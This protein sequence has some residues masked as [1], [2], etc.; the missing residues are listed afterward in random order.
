MRWDR[1]YWCMCP[2]G[3]SWSENRPQSEEKYLSTALTHK[4]WYK[5]AQKCVW[6]L[7]LYEC[8]YVRWKISEVCAHLCGTWGHL[9][10]EHALR[11]ISS[12]VFLRESW[13]E[14]DT[15]T[16]RMNL[17][18]AK[19]GEK[20]KGCEREREREIYYLKSDRK[21]DLKSRQLNLAKCWEY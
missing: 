15:N 12:T 14:R 18:R 17:I 8:H 3:I 11:L 19:N 4:A 1:I 20:V 2:P 13:S 6:K 10:S 9:P 21:W 7:K 16:G 5:V